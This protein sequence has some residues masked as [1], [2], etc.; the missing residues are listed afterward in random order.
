MIRHRVNHIILSAVFTAALPFGPPLQALELPPE[1]P[2]WEKAPPDR[3]IRTDVKEQVRTNKSRPGSPSGSNRV[4]SSVTSPTYSIHRPRNPNGIGLV[5]CPG[6][7]FRD[8]WIDREGHDLA[9]WLKDHGVTS[10]VLKYRTF[11]AGDMSPENTWQNYQHIVQS[12]GRQAIRILR[13]GA[14]DLGLQPGK[15]GICGFSAGGHLAI[16]CSLD[17][18]P[19]LSEGEVSGMPDFAGLFYPGIPDDVNQVIARRTP[20]GIDTPSICPIFIM[21]ARDDRL[22]PADKC[23]DFCSMLLKAG[24]E[25]ELHVFGKGSHGF[26]LGA[27][28]EKSAAI[29]PTSFV[30][31]LNDSNIIQDK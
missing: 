22:T 25:A 23:I 14:S 3:S 6:G 30:A 15:I 17:P 5:I 28:R 10:L 21:N 18:E 24:V 20:H 7:G 31:W 27:G 16:S 26:D 2:L 19:K 4:F 8:V 12:D 1:L 11:I 9:I 13:K 29:W